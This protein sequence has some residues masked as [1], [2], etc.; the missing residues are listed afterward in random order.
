MT[1]GYQDYWSQDFEPGT[2][3]QYSNTNYVIAA[4][5]VERVAGIPFMDFLRA[6]IFTPLRMTSV[7]NFDAGP[8]SASN[9]IYPGAAGAPGQIAAHIA[10]I[11]L[12]RPIPR[13]P[14]WTRWR[15][16]SRR[17]HARNDRPQPVHAGRKCVLHGAGARGL[18]GRAWLRSRHRPVQPAR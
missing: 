11:I 3:W 18:A 13:A 5:V 17:P 4:A 8:L 10:N 16:A 7:A 14:A 12:L 6:R 1:S 15:V 2:K 9:E